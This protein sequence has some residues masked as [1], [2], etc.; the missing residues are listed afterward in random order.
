MI[1][2]FR[3]TLGARRGRLAQISMLLAMYFRNV[4]PGGRLTLHPLPEPLKRREL[5]GLPIRLEEPEVSG[6]A[7]RY[8]RHTIERKDLLLEGNLVLSHGFLLMHAGLWRLYMGALAL[9]DGAST[10]TQAHA[11]EALRN[12][13]KYYAFHSTFNRLFTAYPHMRAVVE[14]IMNKPHYPAT[15]IRAKL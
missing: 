8:F 9:M 12:V 6:L 11:K 7:E 2:G 1:I 5:R 14:N 3:Q 13:E 15:M 10:P 4:I